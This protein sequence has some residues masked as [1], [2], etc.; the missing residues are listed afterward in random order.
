MMEASDLRDDAARVDATLL[1]GSGL[2][3]GS[4]GKTGGASGMASLGVGGLAAAMPFGA[5]SINAGSFRTSA[6]G[7]AMG[8]ELALRVGLL[9]N[10]GFEREIEFVRDRLR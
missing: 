3:M 1:A 4:S 5:G 8:R 9:S 7:S 10:I 6:W 2:R